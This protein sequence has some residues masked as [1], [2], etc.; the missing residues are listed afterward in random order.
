[1]K[2]SNISKRVIAC[3]L[4]FILS[5]PIIKLNTNKIFASSNGKQEIIYKGSGYDVEYQ[6]T[7]SW[8]GA[9]N[10]N[11]IIKN[12]SDEIIDNWAIGFEMPYEITNIWNGVV[13]E[14]KKDYYVIKNAG[15]NQDIAIG[16]SVSFGF[17]AKAK[18]KPKLPKSYD[19]LCFEENVANDK[20]ETSFKV[21]SNWDAAFNGEILLKN[22]SNSTIEDW[23]LQF[24]F[25]PIIDRFW[26]AEIL[27]HQ[28]NHYYIKNAGY[29]ANIKPGETIHLG[30]SANPGGNIKEPTGYQ[31]SQIVQN[32]GNN[33]EDDK[34]E[35]MKDTDGDGLADVLE[36]EIGTDYQKADTDGDGLPDGNE[37]Y[38]LGTNP[39]KMDTDG[40]G[41]SDDKEDYDKDKLS[42]YEEY[43]N[44]TNPYNEDTDEDGL[45]DYEEIYKCHTNPIIEDTDEDEILDGDEVKLGLNPLTKYTK[46]GQLDSECT[47]EQSV[48]IECFSYIN[49]NNPFEIS[50]KIKAAGAADSLIQVGVSNNIG[51]LQDN[52]SILGDVISFQYDNLKFE[53]MELE[54]KIDSSYVNKNNRNYP[55]EK[56]LEGVQRYQVFCYDSEQR[57]LYPVATQ[58]DM[59]NN[60]ISIITNKLGDY[61]IIDMD[62]WLYEM[63]ISDDKATTN[64]ISK[65]LAGNSINTKITFEK[66]IDSL[67]ESLI[68]LH[69]TNIVVM[70]TKSSKY[71][72]VTPINLCEITLSKTP[73]KSDTKTN[74]DGDKLPNSKEIDWTLI[75]IKKNTIQLPT[76]KEYWQSLKGFET[77]AFSR[78]SNKLEKEMCS[79]E[80]L[81]LKSN[82]KKSDTDGDGYND[83]KDPRPLYSDVTK[84]KLI[85]DYN[86]IPVE[87]DGVE[88]Y[89]KTLYYGGNQSWFYDKKNNNSFD[90]KIIEDGGCGALASTDLIIYLSQYR[91]KT[92]KVMPFKLTKDK[93]FSIPYMSYSDYTDLTR[94]L[95]NEYIKP[96]TYNFFIKKGTFGYLPFQLK[97]MIE[98]YLKDNDINTKVNYETISFMKKNSFLNKIKKQLKNDIPV[99]IMVGGGKSTMYQINP[100]TNK[101]VLDDDGD[102]STASLQYH[103]VN[104]VGVVEDKIEGTITLELAS[105]GEKYQVDFNK[106]YK[107]TGALDS[108]LIIK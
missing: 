67:S 86:F 42:N 11:V 30:F 15:S 107:N 38:T 27:E 64:A 14:K 78:L 53:Q 8:S 95:V 19:L 6:I 33:Q 72:A 2:L 29:S 96:N 94:K 40:N 51:M 84:T 55:N 79:I 99:P 35:E 102:Q 74:D 43:K 98:A 48:P 9:F 63:G 52:V 47:I 37:Y 71:N 73:S 70:G 21:T 16:Q 75:K 24:D 10:A 12:T 20:I 39:S 25:E 45:S 100:H 17:S 80:V 77:N 57:A 66:T 22:I 13:K 69:N 7:S 1:M 32:I 68:G 23:K 5:F 50:V 104:I 90:D 59:K 85:N 83:D 76:L 65:K 3:L 31:L 87:Y 81:P 93:K 108:I 103:W 106:V 56:G 60:C 46:D 4:V 89:N 34:D 41:M 58:F 44:G 49:E 105:W 92:K 62:S 61:C 28:G 97:Y 54:F 36:K 101:P 88:A 91:N 26:T 18:T 82:P